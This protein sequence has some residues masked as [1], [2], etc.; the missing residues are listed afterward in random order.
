MKRSSCASGSGNVPSCSIAF[1]VAIRRNG[2]GERVRDAVDRDLPL[3]H[4]LEQRRLRLRQRAVDL[5]D[6][7][8]VRE[9]RAGLELERPVDRIPDR[10]AGDV[11]R[12]EVGRALDATGPR[13]LDR[14]RASERASIV[15]AVPGTSSNSTWPWQASAART[16]RI[17]SVFPRT[18]DSTL[19]R[20]RSTA[21]NAAAKDSLTSAGSH[22]A[23]PIRRDIR[24]DSAARAGRP[25]APP[26]GSASQPPS[27]TTATR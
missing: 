4:P 17:C 9:D 6:D 18:T 20:R 5:V 23:H 8:H 13:P 16:R 3:R 2:C 21:A 26:P 25:E 7:E 19:T 1:S 22:G 11:R 12:L 15:F 10:E 27:E 14:A 24:Q